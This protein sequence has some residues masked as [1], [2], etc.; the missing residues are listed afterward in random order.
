MFPEMVDDLLVRGSDDWVMLTELDWVVKSNATRYGVSLDPSARISVGIEVLRRVIENGLM[1]PGDV[2]KEPPEFVT[3]DLS[4]PA[5]L[6]R[7]ESGWRALGENLQMGDVCWLEN[8]SAG[9]SHAEA[10]L[11]QVNR[12]ANWPPSNQQADRQSDEPERS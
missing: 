9:D 2:I 4:G 10:V 3:W 5:A 8:T 7:I 11:E 12:R 6:E 1:Q